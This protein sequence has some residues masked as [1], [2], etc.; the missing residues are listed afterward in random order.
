ML[1]PGSKNWQLIPPHL[2]NCYITIVNAF[3]G[4][5]CIAV[6]LVADLILNL[7]SILIQHFFVCLLLPA[8]AKNR[9]SVQIGPKVVKLL[10]M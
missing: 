3:H 2:T 6:F 10:K 8:F 1:P 5:E 7:F 9:G 4:S